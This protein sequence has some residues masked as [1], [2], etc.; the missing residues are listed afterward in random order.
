MKDITY[1]VPGNREY[2]TSGA[3]GYYTYFQDKAFAATPG[4]YS[5]DIGT[6][7][8]IALNSNC[9]EVGGCGAGSAQEQWLRTD[10]AAHPNSCTLAYWHHPR[11]S[12]K[13]NDSGYEPFW[14]ALY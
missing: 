1:P 14:Q 6:W 5:F 10:L 8:L 3:S 2:N 7:H 9:S 12:S 4:Y 13:G 11:F